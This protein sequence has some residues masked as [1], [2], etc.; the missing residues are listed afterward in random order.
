MWKIN[1][2]N[3]KVNFGLEFEVDGTPILIWIEGLVDVWNE[4]CSY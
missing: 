2:G 3:Y 4:V 1:G